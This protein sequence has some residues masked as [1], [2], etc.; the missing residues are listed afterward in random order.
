LER[1]VD[2]VATQT[3][4]S[5]MTEVIAGRITPIAAGRIIKGLATTRVPA[6]ETEA[7]REVRRYEGHHEAAIETDPNAFGHVDMAYH[8]G[9]ITFA[10]LV[11]IHK[12][13]TGPAS[14]A[15][16]EGRP[17]DYFLHGARPVRRVDGSLEVFGDDGRWTASGLDSGLEPCTE[18][19]A[20]EAAKVIVR[21]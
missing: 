2:D 4:S 7:Q 3:V 6:N 10:Q 12:G 8:A 5:V 15:L 19:Q 11:Q 9:K 16:S 14:T 20:L 21:G 1:R 18:N 17:V 13:V